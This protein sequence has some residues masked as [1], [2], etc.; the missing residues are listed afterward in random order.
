MNNSSQILDNTLS[1]G[2]VGE[3]NIF[4]LQILGK[5]LRRWYLLTSLMCLSWVPENDTFIGKHSRCGTNIR[6]IPSSAL[7]FKNFKRF[8]E[9]SWLQENRNLWSDRYLNWKLHLKVLGKS[10]A[11]FSWISL[12]SWVHSKRHWRF[13]K[14]RGNFF[15]KFSFNANW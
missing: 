7:T 13:K 4:S 5:Q 2:C 8:Q 1:R 14:S 11:G 3:G 6:I 9:V 12:N 15:P 10:M